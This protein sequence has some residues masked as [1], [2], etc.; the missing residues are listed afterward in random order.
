MKFYPPRGI[1]WGKLL[2]FNRQEQFYSNYQ[3]PVL[4]IDSRGTDRQM[5]PTLIGGQTL[6]D[7]N[8]G[9]NIRET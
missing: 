9:T 7:L 3:Q 8:D 1:A 4:F 6:F 2:G 5:Q